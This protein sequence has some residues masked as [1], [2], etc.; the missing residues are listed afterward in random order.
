MALGYELVITDSKNTEITLSSM[1]DGHEGKEDII[2][3]SYMS[4][5]L[6]DDAI[7]RSNDVRA[8]IKIIGRITKENKKQTCELANWSK[9]TNSELIYRTIKLITHPSSSDSS[10]LRSYE[11]KNMFVLD[12][13][14]GFEMPIGSLSEEQ[15]KG[16]NDNGLF[17]IYLVQKNGKYDQFIEAE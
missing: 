16:E 11:I 4:N 5:T 14:E 17:E 1:S 9:E 8:E 7:A 2:C 3:V 13:T 15:I 12:Y 10:I 6:N